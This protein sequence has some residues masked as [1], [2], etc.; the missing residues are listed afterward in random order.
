MEKAAA[1]L[2]SKGMKMTVTSW[3]PAKV[4]RVNGVDALRTTYTRRMNDAPPVLVNMFMIQN[5]DR[6]HR[7]TV[8]YRVAE[9]EKWARDLDKVADTFKFVKR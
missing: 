4:V 7:I 6:M 5:N 1:F 9:T 8:S 3:Q 2:T